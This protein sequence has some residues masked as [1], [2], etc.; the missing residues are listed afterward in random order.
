MSC[1]G[2]GWL[3]DLYEDG[4]DGV[5]LWFIM[6][7]GRRIC[8]RQE[9]PVSFYEEEY[10]RIVVAQEAFSLEKYIKAARTGRGT[11]LDRKKRM[12]IWK[13]AWAI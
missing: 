8:L 13:W 6:D 2:K 11:R 5:R 12:Q 10:N 7:D 9:F 4:A 3:L 1:T